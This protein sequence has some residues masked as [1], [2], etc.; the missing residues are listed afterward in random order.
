M[1]QRKT[2]PRATP[3]RLTPG[4]APPGTK[5]KLLPW[6]FAEQRL[7]TAKNYWICTTRPDR[8]P[9]AAP[10]WGLWL[11]RSFFFSTDPDSRKAK[12]LKV[13]SDVVVHLESGDEV[14]IIEGVAEVV[15]LTPALDRAYAKKYGMRLVGFPA[16][17]VIFEVRPR[18]IMAWREKAFP[19][20]ATRWQLTRKAQVD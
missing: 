9:H 14:V 2:A 16:P 19:A 18:A 3:L 5:P 6:A 12:N 8:R 15:E 20:S 13:R 11:E 7:K 1:P 4:Y 17:M 10:V